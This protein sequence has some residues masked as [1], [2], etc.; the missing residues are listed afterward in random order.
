MASALG[1]ALAIAGAGFPAI[2]SSAEQ[3]AA[4]R[5]YAL[6][7]GLTQFTDAAVFSDTGEYD[8]KLIELPIP[9]LRLPGA[10]GG[11]GLGV[12]LVRRTVEH[13]PG[14]MDF[15]AAPYLF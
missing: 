8:G 9:Y 5:L 13:V 2:A 11:E 1:A 14:L 3:A 10:R 4:I 7:C 15:V 12:L 6:D